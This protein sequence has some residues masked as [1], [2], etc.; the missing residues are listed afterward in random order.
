MKF[1]NYFITKYGRI[2]L[3]NASDFL[4]QNALVLLHNA[5]VIIKCDGFI[6]KC[7]DYYKIGYI[8]HNAQV[9]GQ[10]RCSNNIKI[11]IIQL[12]QQKFMSF[13]LGVTGFKV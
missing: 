5:T 13:L 12:T 3:Q 8:L 1:N 4:P 6:K 11:D 10:K 2:F 9:Q 7:D